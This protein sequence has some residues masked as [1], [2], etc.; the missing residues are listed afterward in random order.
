M[1]RKTSIMVWLLIFAV[2]AAVAHMLQRPPRAP[3]QPVT[4]SA[5]V[6]DGDSL[7]I[8]GVRIRLHGIDAP[9]RDQDCRDAN[10]KTYSCGRAAMRALAAAVDGRSVT[11]TPVQVDRY[12]RDIATCTVDGVDLGETMV[13]AGHALDYARHSRGRYAGAEREARAARRGLWAGTFEAPAT[14]RQNTTR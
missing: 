11:C 6:I 13:R 12:N 14:W 8:A 1:R 2:L 10:G 4:G 7:E 3:G 5:R 9:E